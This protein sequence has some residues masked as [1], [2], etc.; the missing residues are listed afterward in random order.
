ME[1]FEGE[2]DKCLIGLEKVYD[3]GTKGWLR[4][5][6]KFIKCESIKD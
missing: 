6:E 5:Y 4:Y 1:K 2:L 3:K